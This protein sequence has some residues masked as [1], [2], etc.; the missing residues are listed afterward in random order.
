MNRRDFL[1]TAGGAS[2]AAAA[3]TG[4]AAAQEEGGGG[5]NVQPDWGGYLDGIDGGYQD[6]RG[7]SE[8]TVDVGAD[9]N[10][11]ALAFAPAGIWVDPGT[12][13]VW[14]WTGEGGG[15]N[16]IAEEGPASLDSGAPVAEAGTTFEHTFSEDEAGITK[17]YCSPH[18]A[19]GMLGAVAVGGDVPT[20]S[21]GGGGEKELEELGVPIQAH[22]V[23]AATILGIIVTIIYTFY[24]LKYGESPNTGNTGGGE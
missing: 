23:G 1:R 21:T 22:W 17:Y 7:Q 13:V 5:G 24:I 18:Q 10:G 2:V 8:V 9:G 4:S 19:L 15:H 20:V 11:G 12:T 3:A 16:V 14:E 6:L